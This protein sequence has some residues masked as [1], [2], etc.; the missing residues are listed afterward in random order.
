M[1][2]PG[3]ERRLTPRGYWAPNWYSAIEDTNIE[4]HGES[5]TMVEDTVASFEPDIVYVH[6]V[7]DVHQDHRAVH[8]ASLVACRSVAQ[9]FCYQSPSATVDFRPTRFVSVEGVLDRKLEAISAFAS[10]VQIRDYLDEDLLRSTARYWGRFGG[11]RYAEP[12]EVVRDSQ[13]V[14]RASR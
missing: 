2:R 6:S 13:E 7:H 9:I 1:P 10:Q 8:R 12:F 5:V 4:E 14:P 11:C 3:Q